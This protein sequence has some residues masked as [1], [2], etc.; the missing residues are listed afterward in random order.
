MAEEAQLTPKFH[1]CSRQFFVYVTAN[2]VPYSKYFFYHDD[3]RLCS[4]PGLDHITQKVENCFYIYHWSAWK[5][6]RFKS[7]AAVLAPLVCRSN[8]REIRFVKVKRSLHSNH[9]KGR[10]A[11][12][13]SRTKSCGK[14]SYIVDVLMSFGGSNQASAT[15]EDPLSLRPVQFWHEKGRIAYLCLWGG[16]TDLLQ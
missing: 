3:S 14:L 11:V 5:K 15:T 6:K 2:S 7:K 13:V 8:S 4:T 9:M 12:W 10:W 1:C 16:C